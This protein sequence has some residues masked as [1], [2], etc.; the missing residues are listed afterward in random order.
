MTAKLTYFKGR[1]RAETTRWMLAANQIE[2]ENCVIATAQ[3]LSELRASEKLPFDQMPLLEINDRRLSQSSA[4]IRYLARL[5]GFYGDND[6]EAADCDLVAGVVADFA[7]AGLQAAF[8]PTDQ[9]ATELLTARFD[10]FGPR[11]EAWLSQNGTGVC[12]GSRVSFADIV[13]AEA[14]S[15]YLE[16]CSDILNSTPLMKALYQK[17]LGLPGIARYLASDLRYPMPGDT[18][19]ID[20]ARV[21][22]RALPSHM[23]DANQFV[24]GS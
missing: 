23:A 17:V 22:E 4:M 8:Q 21:L 1:G 5:G 2:F 9:A 19:V 10:K 11:F 14:L 13:M 7:E 3:E 24:R 15:G 18:Y 20:V 6:A 12:A 16:R